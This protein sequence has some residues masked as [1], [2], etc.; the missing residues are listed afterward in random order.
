MAEKTN[1][2]KTSRDIQ[3]AKSRKRIYEAALAIMVEKGFD[4]TSINDICKS[5]DCSVGAFY[6]HFPSKDSILEETFRIADKDF[7]GWKNFPHIK[8]KGHDLILAYMQSYAELVMQS[9]LEF[10][11]RFYTGKNKVFIRRGRPMQTRLIEIVSDAMNKKEISLT[12]SA[13]KCCENL[14]LCARGV[15]LHWCLHEGEFDL[16]T[17]MTEISGTILR[18]M[19]L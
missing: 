4:E 1:K 10:S 5:A 3:A 18:G 9:G 2:K 19:E 12:V 6:H 13:E 14:F 15:V 8:L 17:K 11:K 7:D 16:K